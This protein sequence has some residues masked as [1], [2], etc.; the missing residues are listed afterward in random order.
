VGFV[1]GHVSSFSHSDHLVASIDSKEKEAAQRAE[2]A[3][4]A[5]ETATQKAKEAHVQRLAGVARKPPQA[6]AVP[7]TEEQVRRLRL[8]KQKPVLVMTSKAKPA[9]LNRQ[10]PR[11]RGSVGL[12]SSGS[13]GGTEGLGHNTVFRSTAL[14]LYRNTQKYVSCGGLNI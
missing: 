11:P 8:I 13:G 6:P 7:P 1:C 4:N 9:D 3:K 5:M 10:R 14:S 2:E 12:E